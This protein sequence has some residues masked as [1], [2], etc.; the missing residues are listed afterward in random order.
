LKNSAAT[1]KG[2]AIPG[3]TRIATGAAKGKGAL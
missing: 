1:W 2:H 3:F